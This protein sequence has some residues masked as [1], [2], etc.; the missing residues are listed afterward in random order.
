MQTS[1]CYYQHILQFTRFHCVR[2]NK[3]KQA[4]IALQE[5]QI[6]LLYFFNIK[7]FKS[8]ASFICKCTNSFKRSFQYINTLIQ[9]SIH[10]FF[11]SYTHW[12]SRFQAVKIYNYSLLT[13]DTL[14]SSSQLLI[15]LHCLHLQ[16]KMG[17]VCAS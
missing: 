7:A 2:H 16:V 9:R 5:I 11:H 10:F 12:C 3:D 15:F 1:L 13:Y 8:F 17:A 6:S 4:G 14:Q